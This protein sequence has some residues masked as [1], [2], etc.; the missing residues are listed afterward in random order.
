MA[1]DRSTSQN[2]VFWELLFAAP[3]AVRQM[4][5]SQGLGEDPR[6][7]GRRRNSTIVARIEPTQRIDGFEFMA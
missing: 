4:K 2:A 6:V 7:K 3:A 5:S 1:G